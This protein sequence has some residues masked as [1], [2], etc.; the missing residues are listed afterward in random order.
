MPFNPGYF[1]IYSFR[2]HHTNC[3]FISNHN[4]T[5]YMA[6]DCGWPCTYHEYL[7]K[8]KEIGI[9]IDKVHY[10]IVSHF[11]LDHAGLFGQ[12]QEENVTCIAFDIQLPFIDT[13]E[14]TI[15]KNIEYMSYKQ[16]NKNNLI[17]Y[18]IYDFNTLLL[19]HGF[20]GHIESLNAH[21]EDSIGYFSDEKVVLIGDLAPINQVMHDDINGNEN[22]ERIL[23]F[24]ATLA[25][26]SHAEPI[27]LV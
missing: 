10:V 12:F 14:H 13:M 7:K 2:Y 23:A 16:I 26:P 6:F 18:T 3:F 19:K 22:W 27:V 9:S 21:S 11:H 24:G 5:E 20:Q 17:T 1:M 15:K 4:E 8:T 25:L